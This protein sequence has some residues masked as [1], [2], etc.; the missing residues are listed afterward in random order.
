MQ[1][2]VMLDVVPSR[3]LS[4]IRDFSATDACSSFA[5]AN[6]E[7]L[8]DTIIKDINCGK[9][10]CQDVTE[11]SVALDDHENSLMLSQINAS[12]PYKALEVTLEDP[13]SFA[14]CAVRGKTERKTY[15]DRVEDVISAQ[16][17]R[18]QQHKTSSY[19]QNGE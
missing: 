4:L 7:S 2:G 12:T 17:H 3:Y 13:G 16:Y 11:A 5:M 8:L 14:I 9:F 15:V 19:L 1:S 10:L 6:S 18:D